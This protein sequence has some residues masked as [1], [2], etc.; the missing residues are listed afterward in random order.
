MQ[1]QKASKKVM[2]FM[3]RV[4]FPFIVYIIICMNIKNIRTERE[5]LIIFSWNVTVIRGMTEL[6]TWPKKLYAK[7]FVEVCFTQ[8]MHLKPRNLVRYTFALQYMQPFKLSFHVKPIYAKD[9]VTRSRLLQTIFILRQTMFFKLVIIIFIKASKCKKRAS[10]QPLAP[11]WTHLLNKK[12][13]N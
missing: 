4:I 9:Y 5:R 7:A 6:C 8:E 12:Y 1:I 3:W 2:V 11:I 13:S 10:W